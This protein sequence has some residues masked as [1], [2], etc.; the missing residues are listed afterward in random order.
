MCP[1]DTVETLRTQVRVR[2]GEP[3]AGDGISR[4]VRCPGSLAPT[5]PA[6]LSA[7]RGHPM[8]VQM[9]GI[10]NHDWYVCHARYVRYDTTH[11]RL[12]IIPSIFFC[13]C[14]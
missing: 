14:K 7:A 10:P 11:T 9:A 6:G 4:G 3:V 8:A 13:G 2:L 5:I 1:P 12:G